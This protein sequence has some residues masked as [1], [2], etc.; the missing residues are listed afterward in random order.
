M[1]PLCLCNG[2]LDGY[3]IYLSEIV[4]A[5]L[6]GVEISV[7]T[8]GNRKDCAMGWESFALLLMFLILW[9]RLW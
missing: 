7:G 4:S 6:L 3:L 2:A 1:G 9:Q 8:F 5:L